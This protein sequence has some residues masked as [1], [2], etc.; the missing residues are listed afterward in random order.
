MGPIPISSSGF[1]YRNYFHS[2]LTI[3]PLLQWIITKGKIYHNISIW[4]NPYLFQLLPSFK[5]KLFH[6]QKKCLWELFTFS[7][8]FY[9]LFFSL[10]PS[11]TW[12]SFVL[13][14]HPFPGL[15]DINTILVKP[16]SWQESA[17]VLSVPHLCSLLDSNEMLHY[18]AWDL[19]FCPAI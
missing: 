14:C 17:N 19:L 10:Q 6:S 3:S 11:K 13:R 18:M 16:Q 1:D 2:C 12:V 8:C 9:P 7:V 5:L 4:E 15:C